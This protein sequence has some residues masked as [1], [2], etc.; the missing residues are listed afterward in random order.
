MPRVRGF[1][2][3]WPRWRGAVRVVIRDARTGR[4]AGGR[5]FHNLI[6]DP[7]L[8]LLRDGLIGAATDTQIHYVALGAGCGVLATG[9]TNGQ[10]SITAL[11]MAVG[12][13]FALGNGQSLT[14]MNGASSQVVTTS[15]TVSAGATSIPV[16]SFTANAN[17]SVSTTRV[18]PTP[19]ATDTTLHHETFRKAVTVQS[20]GSAGVGT[21]TLYVAPQDD[22]A[23]IAEI[24]WF[25][26]ASATG[27][28]GSGA[29][30]ARVLYNHNHTNL[31]SLQITRQDTL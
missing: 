23:V 28:T 29:M 20:A 2:E 5:T 26:G 15:S 1:T 12:I 13:P 7:G 14:L 16:T 19:A 18:T 22:N 4:F 8:N 3:R 10:T 17:Y 9:L 6:C 27:A 30:V 21:T 24:G 25:A 31:E 11:A